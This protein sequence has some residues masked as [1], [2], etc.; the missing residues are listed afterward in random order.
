MIKVEHIEVW[1]FKHAVRGL[2]NP[3]NSWDKSDS[4]TCNKMDSCDECRY[5]NSKCWQNES[6]NMNIEE[7]ILG[8]NDLK[9][10]NKLYRA[11]GE[12]RKYLRQIFV[13]FDITA[14][15]Y[16]WKDFSTYKFAIPDNDGIHIDT[17]SCSTMHKIHAKEFE[18]GDFSIEHLSDEETNAYYKNEGD[19]ICIYGVSAYS[20]MVETVAVLNAY[21]EKYIETGDKKWWWQMIQLL[22]ESYNQ[23]RTVTM[24]YETVMS[25]IKQRTGHKLD[26]WNSFVATLRTLPYVENI[27]SGTFDEES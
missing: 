23:K 27:I 14:P 2:R 13:S 22:P 18:L 16:W 6:L 10:M 9:L 3:M 12:H 11:G 5:H 25:I 15:F 8:E 20:W 21:R 17:D 1:G 24:S 19:N 4:K 7:Y 26:E